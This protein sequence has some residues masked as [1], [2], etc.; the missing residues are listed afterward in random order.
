[1]FPIQFIGYFSW[2][3]TDT[4]SFFC[5]PKLGGIREIRGLHSRS[6]SYHIGL[7]RRSILGNTMMRQKQRSRNAVGMF[8]K[9]RK[10]SRRVAAAR[11]PLVR[12]S[13]P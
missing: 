7:N 8:E 12:N 10:A 13:N 1:M 9:I 2:C 11:D 5:F 6:A 4:H 3:K